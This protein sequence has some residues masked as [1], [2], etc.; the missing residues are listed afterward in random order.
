MWRQ[1]SK[2]N[3]LVSWMRAI[4]LFPRW[5]LSANILVEQAPNCS[6]I[7]LGPFPVSVG[8]MHSFRP[9]WSQ[10][11]H[12]R[13]TEHISQ[14]NQKSRDQY[15]LSSQ[16]TV[17]N[18]R[19]V[20]KPAPHVYSGLFNRKGQTGLDAWYRDKPDTWRDVRNKDTYMTLLL[21]ST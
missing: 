12:R 9:F 4:C 5:H 15:S 16:P 18:T 6:R 19:W 8:H 21:Q 1:E 13:S 2:V 11:H 20:D 17:T 14:N 10:L 7:L 3:M